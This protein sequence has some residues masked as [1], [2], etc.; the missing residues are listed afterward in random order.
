[1]TLKIALAGAMLAGFVL[2][3]AAQTTYYIV[4]DSGGRD[5]HIVSQRPVSREVTVIGEDGYATQAQAET[6]MKT[7]KVCHG[8]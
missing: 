1:M 7:V 6:A 3:A 5:C 8:G 2:P 4:Q